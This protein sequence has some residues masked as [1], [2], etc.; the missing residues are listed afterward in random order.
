MTKIKKLPQSVINQI[1]AGEVVERPASVV[2]ELIENSID[3]KSTQITVKIENAGKKLIEIT[4]NGIG[5]NR[6]DAKKAFE[7]HSTSKISSVEDLEKIDTMGF[8]GEALA[9]ISS[10]SKVSLYTKERDSEESGIKAV[11]GAEKVDLIEETGVEEGARITVEN[12]FTN[13]PARKKFLKSDAT[14]LKYITDMFVR[15]SL[16]RPGIHFELHNNG[17]PLYILPR[18]DNLKQRVFDLF[19]GD[20]SSKL[21]EVNYNS[22][23]IQITGFTGHPSVSQNNSNKQFIFLNNRPV[24]EKVAA[25]A[26][27]TA[28]HTLIPGDKYPV[29]F[30]LIKIDPSR[31]DVNVHPRKNEVKFEDSQSLFMAVK[32]AV[33]QSLHNYLQSELRTRVNNL[34]E[35]TISRTD[36]KSGYTPIPERPQWKGEK[37]TGSKALNMKPDVSSIEESIRFSQTILN[38][39]EN[40]PDNQTP[41]LPGEDLSSFPNEGFLQIFNTYLLITKGERLLII[42]QHAAAERIT[43]EELMEKYNKG[44]KIEQ[45]QL[46]TPI[47]VDL[48]PYLTQTLVDNLE[49]FRNFGFNIEEFGEAT[50]QVN[51]IPAIF[52]ESD[53]ESLLIETL[54]I[55]TQE[56]K[57][58]TP[59]ETIMDRMLASMA[60]H[61]S[62]RAGQKLSR[63]Q[64]QYLI[65]KLLKCK[66]PYSCPH[67]RP[68][69][70]EISRYEI[71][72]KFKRAK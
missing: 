54:E 23:T 28:F 50:F 72:K 5:M 15:L 69:I 24:H 65:E 60:C 53:I 64:T 52:K 14:E 31:V 11:A 29:Y 32:Q 46:L 12:L 37:N 55:L 48:K 19:G 43:Y 62:I 27:S 66:K 10:V 71:E 9:S 7:Q 63:E 17:K 39:P 41:R 34:E 6:E 4:D 58:T 42:D 56:I 13:V 16:S 68:I 47:T 70:W 21:I 20:I 22:P 61:G 67:G 26:I 33:E 18:T 57:T 25:K 51:S 2:K 30:L 59:I 45:Q 8:R 38:K 44:E 40:D 49:N 36:Y 35:T 1:A 3:A